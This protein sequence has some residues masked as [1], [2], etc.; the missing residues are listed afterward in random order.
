MERR[1]IMF[2][3][4][5]KVDGETFISEL[6]RGYSNEQFLFFENWTENFIIFE[7]QV[8]GNVIFSNL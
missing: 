5:D 2:Y 3:V 8:S 4:S 6:S 1:E 7:F